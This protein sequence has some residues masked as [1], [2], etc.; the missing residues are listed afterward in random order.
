MDM[1][2]IINQMVVLFI[3]IALGY[4]GRKTKVLPSETDSVLT[5]LVLNITLP[6]T[7]LSSVLDGNL[8]ITG[9]ETAF[10]MLMVLLAL[11]ISMVV[12]IPASRVI[13]IGKTNHGIYAAVIF[14]GN[15][16]FMGFPMANA[17]FGI[18]STFY[19]AL[20]LIF[21][22]ILSFALG[23]VLISGK[24]GKFDLSALRNPALITSLIVIPLALFGVRVPGMIGN[25]VSLIGSVTIPGSML[26]IGFMLGQ[27]S[28]RDTFSEW[29]LYIITL[30]KLIVIPVV[31][32]LVLRLLITDELMLG[33]LVVLS[34][35]PTAAIVAMFA[36]EY[37][38]DQ[39]AAS[40]GIF[41]TTLLSCATVPL[42]VYLLL[43]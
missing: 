16:G 4:T 29:R 22:Q 42:I 41:L 26:I 2:V 43:M 33:V 12:A 11:L 9:G 27:F 8:I 23:P 28:P 38:G 40:G 30:L 13:C 35:M 36:I 37:D 7:I 3:L 21:F 32:W 15:V 31:T 6:C 19:V 39:R 20:N 24:G 1:Q 17:I 25:A 10:F 14:M 34:A 5:K 18:E